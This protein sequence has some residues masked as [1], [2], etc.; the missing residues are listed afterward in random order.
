M[1][2]Q[3]AVQ[4]VDLGGLNPTFEAADATN[5]NSFKNY[6]GKTF[7]IVDNQDAVSKT[8]T[9]DSLV[10]CDYGEDHDI[11]V[12]VPAGEQRWIGPFSPSRFND[13]AGLVSFSVDD[14]TS[15]M[16]AAIRV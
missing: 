2:T 8:V 5:G 12:S 15:V 9:I 6:N 13:S 14:D 4:Q 7:L 16:V 1:P 11:Q 3:I 10:K